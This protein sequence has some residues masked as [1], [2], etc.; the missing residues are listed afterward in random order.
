MN[1]TAFKMALAA[2]ASTGLMASAQTATTTTTTTAPAAATS[3]S[4]LTDGQIVDLVKI[5]NEGEVDLGKV[6]K[7]KAE[8]KDVKD[9]AKKM[10]DEH[11]KGEKDTKEVAKKGKIKAIETQ[12]SKDLKNSTKDKISSLKKLKGNEFDKAY[13]G[14]QI[15]V[16][17]AMLDDLNNKF[18]PAAQ[19]PELK[20]H[21]EA[22]K[23]H[24]QEH[25][26]TAQQLQTTLTK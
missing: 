17:Q 25:L 9:F 26:A 6:G 20:A 1:H 14:A 15:E 19:N 21:L 3:T 5:A 13:I 10:V 16:H 24:V 22:T 7:S 18:I 23:A 2:L 11:N 12:A 4:G 8:N